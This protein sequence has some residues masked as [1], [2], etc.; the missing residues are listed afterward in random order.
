MRL[1]TF[2]LLFIS[3][4]AVSS[5]E[6]RGGK[7]VHIASVDETLLFSISGNSQ[8]NRPSCAT[9]SRFSVHKDS[10]HAAV[11]LTAFS[12]GKELAHVK[13]LGTCKLWGNSEDIRWVE[14]CPLSG[15]TQ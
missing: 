5:G 15:C 2:V 6:S 14:V 8:S 3:F 9:S 7:V 13:G 11:V 4:S 12:T 10:V 1:F